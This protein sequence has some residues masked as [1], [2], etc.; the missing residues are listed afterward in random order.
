MNRQQILIQDTTTQTGAFDG[1]G[2]DVS[3]IPT[4]DSKWMLVLEIFAQTG[5]AR[6]EFADSVDG[7]VADA[8]AGPTFSVKNGTGAGG[9]VQRF[10]V[11][12]EDFPDLRVGVASAELRLS[13][14]RLT[15]DDASV[16]Y[17]AWLEY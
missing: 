13:V 1:D 14:T 3:G 2:V 17:R 11:N 8:L 12:S 5:S 4:T 7:F 15:G 9:P 6:L 16:T 10:I